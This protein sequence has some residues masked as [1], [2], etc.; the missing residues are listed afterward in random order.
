MSREKKDQRNRK[1]CER[2]RKKKALTIG[3][4]HFPFFN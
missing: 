2:Q 4:V 3:H 1:E